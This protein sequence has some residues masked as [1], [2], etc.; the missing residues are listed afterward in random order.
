MKRKKG[1]GK[2]KHVRPRTFWD[3]LTA[4]P[5]IQHPIKRKRDGNW[6]GSVP[7]D[8]SFW[9]RISEKRVC[10]ACRKVWRRRRRV[11]REHGSLNKC[12][13]C[14]QPLT[15]VNPMSQVPR[16]ANKAAWRK[17]QRLLRR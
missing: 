10:F 12:P 3:A 5:N 11:V 17:A 1:M 4:P 14:G 7:D 15:T 2:V 6:R 13:E 8:G 9:M 16:R